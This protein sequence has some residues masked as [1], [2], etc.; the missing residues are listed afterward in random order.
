MFKK[1]KELRWLTLGALLLSTFGLV[2]AY[3][4]M[5]TALDI[6]EYN[7]V[8]SVNFTD[9]NVETTGGATATT[10]DVNVTSMNNFDVKL[11]NKG[12]SVTYNFKV[13]NSGGVDAILK[14]V[15]DIEAE[16]LV[17][18][19]NENSCSNVSYEL[20]YG[21]GK[22]V[23]TGDVITHDTYIEMM[24]KVTYNGEESVQIVMD[25]FDIILLYEQV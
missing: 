14:V 8:W 1:N 5:S 18:E 7:N 4:A 20:T 13:K 24:F 9:V 10:P 2:V 25:D 16:C 17:L 3:V 23:S 12:D 19:G 6:K 21:D 15:S 22:S 11:M